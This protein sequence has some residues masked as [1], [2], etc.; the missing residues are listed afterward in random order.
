MRR[1]LNS[2]AAPSTLA[3]LAN[4]WEK[5]PAATARVV[6]KDRNADQQDTNAA[7][8]PARSRWG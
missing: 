6:A 4:G 8:A 1:S 2:S 3:A 7:V 5:R